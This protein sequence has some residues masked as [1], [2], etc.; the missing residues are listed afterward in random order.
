MQKRMIVFGGLGLLG[1][2]LF[3]SS[4]VIVPAGHVGVQVLFGSVREEVL[5]EGVHL[6]NPLLRVRKMSVRLQEYTMSGTEKEGAVQGYDAVT[7]LSQDGLNV[8]LEVT[9]WYRLIPTEA[10]R[11]YRNIGENYVA[12]IVRPGSRTAIREEAVQYRAEALWGSA[13]LK[14]VAEVSGALKEALAPKGIEIERVLLRDVAL[15][16]K[17]RAAIEAKLESD[18]AAQQMKFVLL[19]EAQ[20][21]ERKRIEARGIADF[22]TIVTKGISEALLK[23]KAI[24]VASELGKSPNTKIIILGDKS[25]LPIILSDK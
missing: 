4:C 18:Q 25:G 2:L 15:P 13:R 7:A 16:A 17:I 10:A 11:V 21:A 8:N 22:Q 5:S 24:E 20:E 9:I 3:V 19:K 12:V 6:I 23:W 14:F 1:F